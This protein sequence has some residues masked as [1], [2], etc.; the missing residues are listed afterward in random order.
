MDDESLQRLIEAPTESLRTEVKRWLDLSTAHGQFHL[1]RACLALR[2]GDGG[3][4]LIGFDDATGAGSAEG[5]PDD[6]R[7][8]YHPDTVQALVA[9]YSSQRF[10][11]DVRFVE[12]DGRV[13]P[14]LIVE[15][16]V[17]TP[18]AVKNALVDKSGP[19]PKDLF[20][21][22]DV[23]V[24]TLESGNVAASSK[25][26]PDDWERLMQICFDNR[27]ADIGRFVRRQL[28]TL[29]PETLQRIVEAL[30]GIRAAPPSAK[31]RLTLLLDRGL[32]RYKA[33]VDE[34]KPE[35]PEHGSWEVALIMEGADPDRLTDRSFLTLLGVSNPRY[36][37]WAIWL[38]TSSQPQ[39]MKPRMIED[40]WEA[41][42]VHR[43]FT[44]FHRMRANGE[45]YR[46]AVLDEDMHSAEHRYLH[47]RWMAYRIAEAVGVGLAFALAMKLPT[48]SVLHFG[49]RWTGLRGRCLS[50]RRSYADGD[51]AHD[52]VAHSF[53]ALAVDTP[54]SA[55]A[56]IVQ[57]ALRPMLL[58]FN[59][60]EVSLGSCE[61]WTREVIERRQRA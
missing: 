54:I 51:V 32:E 13:H 50:A 10:E 37:G 42:M 52:D 39:S 29:S 18:V 49:F 33:T 35:L 60:Y 45:F 20:A 16:G 24:R 46:Y 41:L 4:L 40:G 8:H 56:P 1:I 12:R 14:V 15:G 53:V 59:G 3:Q 34:K 19:K 31:D 26:R 48:S 43:E 21:R 11:I 25:A 9:S 30:G 36:T 58:V 55:I 22:G 23:F 44:E 7:E 28:G 2:N 38:D 5:C 61:E 27:E 47:A 6:V 57:S 17:R